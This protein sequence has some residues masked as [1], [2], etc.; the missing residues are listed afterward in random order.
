M[1]INFPSNPVNNQSYSYGTQSWLWANN[2]G[3]WK[4]VAS[5][6]PGYTGSSGY[7]GS[8]GIIGFT[9]SVGIDYGVNYAAKTILF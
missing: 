4:T 6:A 1:P 8:Q 9:G 5:T 7:T 3:T 2:Y